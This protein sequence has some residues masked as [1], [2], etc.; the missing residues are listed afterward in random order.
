M[1]RITAQNAQFLTQK[2]DQLEHWVKMLREEVETNR[3]LSKHTG[4]PSVAHDVINNAMKDLRN[5]QKLIPPPQK[6]TTPENPW[7]ER[8]NDDPSD[9]FGDGHGVY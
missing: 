5:I 3:D 6:G 2:L 4:Q 1:I 7:T 9:P 8:R